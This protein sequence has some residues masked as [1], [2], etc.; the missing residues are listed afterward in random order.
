MA[1]VDATNDFYLNLRE[2]VYV[3]E[4][5]YKMIGEI[6][7][8]NNTIIDS[9][10]RAR[11]ANQLWETAWHIS[12]LLAYDVDDNDAYKIENLTEDQKRNLSDNI[13]LM[14]NY[15]TYNK[16]MKVSDFEIE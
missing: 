8:A 11:L 12:R 9:L 14:A 4:L 10:E 15:F 5:Y 13:Y 3:S 1:T 6:C 2:G 7:S 16:P